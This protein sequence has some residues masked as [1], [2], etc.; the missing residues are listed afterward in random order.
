MRHLAAM[1]AT[2]PRF[3]DQEQIGHVLRGPPGEIMKMLRLKLEGIRPVGF[4]GTT[5]G[6]VFPNEV[7]QHFKQECIAQGS[8]D[9]VAIWA[10]GDKFD[11]GSFTELIAGIIESLR[12]DGHTVFLIMTVNQG[13]QYP[14]DTHHDYVNFNADEV[15]LIV[16]EID[17]LKEVE[18]DLKDVNPCLL[19][20]AKIVWHGKTEVVQDTWSK[21]LED[22]GRECYP[23][24]YGYFLHSIRTLRL[25]QSLGAKDKHVLIDPDA[26]WEKFKFY[27]IEGGERV[28]QGPVSFLELCH[29]DPALLERVYE[30]AVRL[31]LIEQ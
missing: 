15:F 19:E 17:A 30:E 4:A 11:K 28:P 26:F 1:P 13:A 29:Q 22:L 21:N 8:A 10:D 24:S 12:G 14:P 6:N 25:M 5:S 16:D 2:K 3:P 27:K 7:I 23:S 18:N 20:L 9:G 31:H